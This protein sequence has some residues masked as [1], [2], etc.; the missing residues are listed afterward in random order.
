MSTPLRMCVVCRQMKQK[1]ELLRITR[2]KG[3]LSLDVSGKMPGRGAYICRG[4][5][6]CEKFEQQRSFERAFKCALQSELKEN[7]KKELIK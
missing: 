2:N 3:E 6:C 7:I 4:G 5:D 1:A